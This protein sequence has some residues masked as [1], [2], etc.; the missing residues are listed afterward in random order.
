MPTATLPDEPKTDP[1]TALI[2]K[3][4]LDELRALSGEG[5]AFQPALDL[6]TIA[7]NHKRKVAADDGYDMEPGVF[8]VTDNVLGKKVVKIIGP[9]FMGV[10]L[11]V[12]KRLSCYISEVE[13]YHTPEFDGRHE[14]VPLFDAA[15]KKVLQGPGST[16]PNLA[17]YGPNKD[18]WLKISNVLYILI[19]Q[20][21]YR[22]YIRGVSGKA[23]REFLRRRGKE[24][25]PTLFVKFTLSREIKGS[26]VY[27]V[28]HEN[29]EPATVDI[30][31]VLEKARELETFIAGARLMAEEFANPVAAA[32]S[33]DDPLSG[34]DDT[35]AEDIAS[36]PLLTAKEKEDALKARK[37]HQ[38]PGLGVKG[39]GRMYAK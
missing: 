4:Q 13:H 30:A 33:I 26:N 5:T 27:Y 18:Q 12:R 25:L 6:P 37:P 24:P 29:I 9:E 1:T 39:T 20:K 3:E 38:I 21:V 34:G 28:V 15:G 16:L 17:Q 10:I 7:V 19:D 8:T 22:M 35:T 2:P 32:P 14:S 36:N 31:L 11:K 23:F